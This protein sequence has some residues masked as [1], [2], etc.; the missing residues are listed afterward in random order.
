MQPPPALPEH[1]LLQK[2]VGSWRCEMSCKGPDGTDMPPSTGTAVCRPIGSAWIAMDMTGGEGLETWTS[3]LTLGYDPQR[4][5]FVGTFIASMMTFMWVYAGTLDAKTNTIALDTDG[6]R[7]DG[8][9]GLHPYLDTYQF[10]D[11]NTWI[12]R[13]HTKGSDGQWIEFMKA[14]YRRA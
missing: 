1:L 5:Q 8:Q 7:F 9:P 3:L 13:S 2:L 6:P 11:D 4:Q 10:L 12:L 14:T